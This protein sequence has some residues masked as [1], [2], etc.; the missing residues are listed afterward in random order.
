MTKFTLLFFCVL[1][2]LVLASEHVVAV[3]RKVGRVRGFGFAIQGGSS[4]RTHSLTRSHPLLMM[5]VQVRGMSGPNDVG[6]AVRRLPGSKSAD[7]DDDSS[8]K[9]SKGGSKGGD[10]DDDSSGKGS[11]GGDD[12]DSSGKGSKGGKSRE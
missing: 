9:G 11:K 6:G 5:C 4:L 2:A 10:D 8:G 12:D 7:D 3:E 1:A